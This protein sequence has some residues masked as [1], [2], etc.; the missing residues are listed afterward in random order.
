MVSRAPRRREEERLES[1]TSSESRV[2]RFSLALRLSKIKTQPDHVPTLL[3][4]SSSGENFYVDA[5]GAR[6]KKLLTGGKAVRDRDG[7]I[8]E[9]AAFQKGEDEAPNGRVQADRRWFGTS[10]SPASRYSLD[11]DL[12]P[13]ALSGNTRVISQSALDHFRTSLS[14]HVKDPYSVLLKRNKLPMSLLEH[15][16]KGLEGKVHLAFLFELL[17][18]RLS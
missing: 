5:K 16:G 3:L 12:P 13:H 1:S 2:R 14:S 6:K 10:K 4:C 7:K 9:A 8:V 15:E 18:R 17:L 11:T